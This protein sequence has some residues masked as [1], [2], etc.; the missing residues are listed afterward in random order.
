VKK[1]QGI[2]I[3]AAAISSTTPICRKT[4]TGSPKYF[5]HTAKKTWRK[6]RT[7]YDFSAINPL[8]IHGEQVAGRAACVRKQ[9]K[10]L[11]TDAKSSTFDLADLLFEAQ[12]NSYAEAWGFAS[13]TDYASKE[14]GLKPR[15]AQYLAHTVKVCLEVG[16]KR[17]Q[18]EL[19]GIS[20]LRE[21]CTLNP[22]GTYW[23]AAEHVSEPLAEHIVRLILDHYKLNLEQVKDEVLR[24]KGRTG[25]DRPVLR[26]TSYPKSVWEN[27]IK[28]ARELARR[29][30]G[31]SGRDDE[32]N[33]KEYSDGACDEMIFASFLADVNNQPDPGDI[34]EVVVEESQAPPNLPMEAI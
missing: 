12:E 30:L 10:D 22:E 19:A 2:S 20:K 8:E 24:L 5:A 9:L 7:M 4:R 17:E 18:F 31:S 26:T 1:W 15:K 13:L 23:N 34:T 3:T 27:V 28:P 32:G 14:L 6:R 33:A 29:L 25:V 21:I 16:L 11:S